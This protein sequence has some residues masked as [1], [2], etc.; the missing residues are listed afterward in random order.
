RD[1]L[2]TGVQTCA[3]PILESSKS[4]AKT[5]FKANKIPA[6]G[7]VECATPVEAFRALENSQY[8]IVIKADG[9]AA[10][11]GVVIAENPA[12]ARNTVQI[13]RASCR[14]RARDAVV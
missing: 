13:G 8:P 14:E 3:L 7:G 5:F 10:G 6:A 2:V 4:F 11:K 12:E 1:D 9:L